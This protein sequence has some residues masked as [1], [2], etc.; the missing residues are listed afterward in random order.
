MLGSL[1]ASIDQWSSSHWFIYQGR[2]GLQPACDLSFKSV[3]KLDI[4]RTGCRVTLE[5][6]FSECQHRV[7]KDKGI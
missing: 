4:V 6:V 1:S 5:F 3:D 7:S 2:T